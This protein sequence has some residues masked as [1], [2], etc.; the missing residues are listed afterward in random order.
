MH[1]L[2]WGDR[3]TRWF[4]KRGQVIETLRGKGIYQEA[5]DIATQKLDEGKWV[6]MVI[7][8]ADV[9]LRDYSRSIYFQKEGSNR[10]I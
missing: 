3:F 9:E 7:V 5:I 6:S 10:M 8:S 4:F 1:D 2:T